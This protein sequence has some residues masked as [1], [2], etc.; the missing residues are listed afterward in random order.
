MTEDA[1][2][3][4]ISSVK[5]NSWQ[6]PK[7]NDRHHQALRRIVFKQHGTT[8]ERQQTLKIHKN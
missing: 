7:V 2:H 8:T 4:K 5:K 1:K 6:K 3:G